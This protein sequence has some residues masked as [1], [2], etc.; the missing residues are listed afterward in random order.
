ME[1]P[2]PSVQRLLTVVPARRVR[3]G[4]VVAPVGP[5]RAGRTGEPHVELVREGDVVRAIDVTCTCGQRLRLR[6]LYDPEAGGS[7]G[8]AQDVSKR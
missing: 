2:E 3:A 5:P 6:C 4:E 8:H 1:S 7:N